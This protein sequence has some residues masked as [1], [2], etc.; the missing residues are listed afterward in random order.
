MTALA[1]TFL[2][3]V[4]TIVVVLGALG[5]LVYAEYDQHRKPH[6]FAV[7]YRRSHV[8]S[9]DRRWR[10]YLHPQF[11]P[12]AVDVIVGAGRPSL[13]GWSRTYLG[14]MRAASRS[15]RLLEAE[16]VRDRRAF[17]TQLHTDRLSG[18]NQ[19]LG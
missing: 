1:A 9:T 6:R 19:E 7:T 4:Y 18:G 13:A 10:W 8:T 5:V 12:D 2:D 15:R 3:A 16:L 17:L 14:A 11:T